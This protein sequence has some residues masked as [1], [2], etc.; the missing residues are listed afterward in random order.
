VAAIG[1]L[2]ACTLAARRAG[3]EDVEAPVAVELELRLAAPVVPS[4]VAPDAR[5]DAHWVALR[6]FY[7]ERDY[8]PAWLKDGTL[9]PSAHALLAAVDGLGVHG[10]E[11]ERYAPNPA[12]LAA[13]DSGREAWPTALADR[14][15]R[16]SFVL[17]RA[18][19]DLLEGRLSPRGASAYWAAAPVAEIDGPRVLRVA[20]ERQEPDTVL[21]ALSPAHSQYR[22]LL[23]ALDRHRALALAGGWP[24]LPELPLLRRG[25]R[26]PGVVPL[27][28]RLA[29]SRDLAAGSFAAEPALFDRALEQALK[30]FQARHGLAAHGRLDAS[31]RAALDVP[32][33]ERIA[34][35]E[36]NL[37]RWRWLPH[38][39]GPRHVLVNVAAF[40]LHAVDRGRRTERMKVVSGR[41]GETPTPIFSA[42]MTTVVFSPWWNVPPRIAAEEIV[43][44]VARSSAYLGR[45]GLQRDGPRFRQPPGPRNPMGAVKFQL[46]NPFHVFLHDTPEDALFARARRDLSHGCVR[47]E[48]P[49]ALARWALDDPRKWTG[50]RIQAAMNAR[51][52]RAVAL[53]R[54]I[55][56]H[57]AY[58]TVWVEDDGA[59]RFLPDAYGHDEAQRE[60][61]RRGTP[62]QKVAD[63]AGRARGGAARAEPVADFAFRVARGR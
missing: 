33:E 37:E 8:R 63:S 30:A 38:D 20:A 12:E 59:V 2:C 52:E 15:L 7:K 5:R 58:F 22:A 62:W 19:H 13:F 3:A 50:R 55:P 24:P 42:E 49:L 61:L 26:H 35:I 47:V 18:A 36:L 21:G 14:D 17:L 60:L 28:E 46:P 6:R 34:Q 1:V 41:A 45:R 53:P 27:R 56:V 4:W 43:P 25:L 23:D 57:V 40:E 39:L 9:R 29:A 10:L 54:G 48:R 31:T 44:A 32:V 51:V 11:P 16:L